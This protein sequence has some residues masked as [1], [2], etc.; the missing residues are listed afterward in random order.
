VPLGKVAGLTVIVTAAAVMVKLTLL[1]SK[2][3]FPTGW[4]LIRAVVVGLFGT[5]ICSVPSFAVLARI[6]TGKVCPPSVDSRMLT[7]AALIL[8]AVVPATSHVTV[9]GVF[10]C[11]ETGEAFC[12]V[13]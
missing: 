12:V 4:I 11:Q 5:V 13:T 8:L 9:C 3:M 2:K 6:V 10:A 7:F 1:M